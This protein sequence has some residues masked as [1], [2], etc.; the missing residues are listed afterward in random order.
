MWFAPEYGF[1][2]NHRVLAKKLAEGGI[3]VWLS[4]IPESL[5]LPNGTQSIRELDGSHVADM[6]DY[7]HDNTGKKIVVSGE[8]TDD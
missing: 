8:A 1:R 7:A 6:I 4:N 3:E 2:S 5:F